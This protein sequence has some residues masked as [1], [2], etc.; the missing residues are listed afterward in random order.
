MAQNLYKMIGQ[1]IKL[2][3]EKLGLSQEELAARME[4]KSTATVSHFETGLRKISIADLQKISGLLG[5]PLESLITGE[6]HEPALNQFMLRAKVVEPG[7]RKAVA[8]FLAFAEAHAQEPEKLPSNITELRPGLAAGKILQM[9]E[10]K[11]PPIDPLAVAKKLNIPVFDWDFPEDVSGIFATNAR[12]VCIGVNN[13]HPY[14]RQKFTIAHELGHWVFHRNT[15][16]LIDFHS[17]VIS[18]DEEF[19]KNETQA[20]QFAADL[21]MPKDWIEQDYTGPN[22]FSTLA[23]KYGVSEQAFWYRLVTLKLVTNQPF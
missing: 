9:A 22:E 16:L 17:G 13:N 8:E 6:N 11:T 12:G 2:A 10:C 4:Y 14:V 18:E 7:V 19:N 15:D 20:N 5:V 3:R 23:S 21:L 1:R